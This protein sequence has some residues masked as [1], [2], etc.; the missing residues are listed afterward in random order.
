MLYQLSIQ[1]ID[2]RHNENKMQKSYWSSNFDKLNDFTIKH[3]ARLGVL[4]LMIHW[5]WAF[6][7]LIFQFH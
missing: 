3:H 2:H 4:P 7:F 5:G 1:K 6:I